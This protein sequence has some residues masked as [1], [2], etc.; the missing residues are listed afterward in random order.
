MQSSQLER[1]ELYHMLTFIKSA[2]VR[3]DLYKIKC[4]HFKYT[5]QWVLTSVRT[6]V[7]TTLMIFRT[8]LS[9]QEVPHAPLQSVPYH[10]ILGIFIWFNFYHYRLALPVPERHIKG[11]IRYVVYYVWLLSLSMILRFIH[12]LHVSVVCSISLLSSIPL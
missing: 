11:I 9:P 8:F 10:T 5:V 7:T 12:V 6:C 4:T 1:V 3:H 2:L